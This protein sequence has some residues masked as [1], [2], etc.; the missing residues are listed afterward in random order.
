MRHPCLTW[1]PEKFFG[2]TAHVSAEA[3]AFYMVLLSHAW[4]RGGSL[5]NDDAML[6]NMTRLS[7]QKWQAIRREVMSFWYLAEDG[8]W[9]QKRLDVE[10][11]RASKNHVAVQRASHKVDEQMQK[12]NTKLKAQKASKNNG[13]QFSSARAGDPTPTPTSL[14][15]YS[16]AGLERARAPLR[17]R[18][19]HATPALRVVGNTE[20]SQ[21]EAEAELSAEQ[22]AKI[23]EGFD[24][25]VASLSGGNMEKLAEAADGTRAEIERKSAEAK[26]ETLA[27]EKPTFTAS[28]ML[29]AN[30]LCHENLDKTA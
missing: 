26:L 20:P 12:S 14:N 4:L 10:W 18:D 8:C 11:A 17:V 1:W 3:A 30:R 16:I 21:P 9:H 6:R 19:T 29:Q 2:D 22:R 25:L 28:P 7:R 27:Q 5:P 23:A 24:K 15:S 13:Q